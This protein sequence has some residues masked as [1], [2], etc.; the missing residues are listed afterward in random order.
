MQAR[1]ASIA[2]DESQVSSACLAFFK[3]SIAAVPALLLGF[4]FQEGKTVVSPSRNQKCPCL[5]LAIKMM[6]NIR[7]DLYRK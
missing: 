1:L 5:S 3:A 7:S 4:L 2:E 6:L